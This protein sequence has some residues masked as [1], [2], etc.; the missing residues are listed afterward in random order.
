MRTSRGPANMITV[1]KSVN[2]GSPAAC[3]R[4]Q[5]CHMASARAGGV[6]ATAA[7]A[8]APV[9]ASTATTIEARPN[10]AT[11]TLP[12]V[13]SRGRLPRSTSSIR[14]GRDLGEV[15]RRAVSTV[16]PH[17]SLWLREALASE[18]G[19]EA[20]AAEGAQRADIVIVGG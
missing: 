5:R 3:A 8:A 14:S 1:A 12:L 16:H 6:A 7:A 15:H 4:L 19:D 17:R 9:A 11:R 18:T 10:S 2:L 13:A 20:L